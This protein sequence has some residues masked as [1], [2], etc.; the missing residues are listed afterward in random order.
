VGV[1]SCH[2]GSANVSFVDAHGQTLAEKTPPS[3]LRAMATAAGGEPMG[4]TLPP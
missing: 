1:S 3:T 4:G 2:P